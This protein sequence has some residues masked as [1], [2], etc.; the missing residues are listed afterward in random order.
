MA[1]SSTEEC[2]LDAQEKRVRLPQ[3][4]TALGDGMVVVTSKSGVP[5]ISDH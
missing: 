3:G 1:F 5:W 4:Q 2:L